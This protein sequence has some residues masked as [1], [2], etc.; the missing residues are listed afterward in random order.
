MC[1][2]VQKLMMPPV[3]HLC[4]SAHAL[5]YSYAMMATLLWRLF[6][7]LLVS[8]QKERHTHLP[9]N[10]SCFI[11]RKYWYLWEGGDN[12]LG[13]GTTE[14]PPLFELNTTQCKDE[15]PSHIVMVTLLMTQFCKK[16]LFSRGFC[17]IS[18]IFFFK[19]IQILKKGSIHFT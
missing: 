13:E 18:T 7:T 2:C 19:I 10:I 16:T 5:Q 14:L 1:V 12:A 17:L 3:A 8:V 4:R 6:V 15:Q 9:V 11:C